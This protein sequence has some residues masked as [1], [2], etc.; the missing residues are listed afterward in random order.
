MREQSGRKMWKMRNLFKRIS[1][2][3]GSFVS[4]A[5]MVYNKVYNI[6]NVAKPYIAQAKDLYHQASG[7]VKSGIEMGKS[8]YS[9]VKGAYHGSNQP[10]EQ[11]SPEEVQQARMLIRAYQSRILSRTKGVKINFNDIISKATPNNAVRAIDVENRIMLRRLRRFQRGFRGVEDIER[12]NFMANLLAKTYTDARKFTHEKCQTL[13]KEYNSGRL[14]F[15]SH[16]RAARKLATTLRVKIYEVYSDDDEDRDKRSR[17]FEQS[18]EAHFHRMMARVEKYP[19]IANAKAAAA[20]GD[21]SAKKMLA[22]F[23]ASAY[24]EL[25][26]FYKQSASTWQ[27][28]A[29]RSKQG[30]DELNNRRDEE[31]A[32]RQMSLQ[33]DVIDF[34]RENRSEHEARMMRMESQNNSRLA[35]LHKDLAHAYSLVN[36]SPAVKPLIADLERKIDSLR[37]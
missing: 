25:E 37:N 30:I 18:E 16:L 27:K 15:F 9:D 19:T 4:K 35:T 11:P 10:A 13:A 36:I 20:D 23:S 31:E 1:G 24:C 14:L 6:I 7:I 33:N 22:M 29:D 8:A 28:I 34:H 32:G 26:S 12:A 3:F 21:E 17:Q 2:G 5:K